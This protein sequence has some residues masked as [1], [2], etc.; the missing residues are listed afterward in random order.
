MTLEVATT[1]IDV[2]GFAMGEQT[3][4]SAGTPD[5]SWIVVEQDPRPGQDADAG[6]P[7]NLVLGDP[8]D[9]ATTAACP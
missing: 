4:A 6:S 7:I 9:P 3:A 5:N 2:D 8:A 1:E